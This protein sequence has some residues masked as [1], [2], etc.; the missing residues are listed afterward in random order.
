LAAT[1]LLLVEDDEFVRLALTRALNRTGVF[2]VVPAEDG[3]HALELLA[4]HQVD[5]ILTDLQ[6]PVM[7]GLTLLGALLERGV[8]TPV[9]VMTGQKITPELAERLHRYGIA[10]T[11]TKPIELAALAD[12]L[13]RSL[14]PTT[15]GRIAGVTLFGFLQL[16]EVERKT[17]LIVV[18]SGHE[19][20]RLY[21]DRGAL[22][23][24]ETRR[25]GGLAAVNEIVGWPDPRL[26]IFY[27]RTTRDRTIREPLQHILMEAARLLDERGRSSPP[28]EE[29]AALPSV[30]PELQ[31]ALDEAMQID[32]ALGVALVDGA[33]GLTL[34][35]A[36]GSAALNVEL[37]GAGAADFVRAKLRVMAAL[38]VNDTLEDVM[39]TLGKQYHLVRFVGG[40]PEQSVFLYLVLDRAAA[41]LGMARHRLAAIGRGLKL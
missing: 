12:E 28:A 26:E 9:A 14:S 39:I 20:G 3:Q 37:A 4:D 31:G 11:F 10:A 16:L 23:H 24:A 5:A 17:G 8:R 21:F 27:K 18:H 33:S 25:L 38:G 7:D 29:A 34:G 6:M 2:A 36:G 35:V 15:V 1:N 13:Q 32:G 41:N 19:E 30:R 22:V 40:G